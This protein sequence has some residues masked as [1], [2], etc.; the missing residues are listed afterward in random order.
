[1]LNFKFISLS[2][3]IAGRVYVDRTQAGFS[4]IPYTV[5][6]VN[7]KSKCKQ[8]KFVPKLCKKQTLPLP[9]D[10]NLHNL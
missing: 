2:E 7:T 1:M 10:E 4:W 6:N 5:L 9:F 8:I 3:D